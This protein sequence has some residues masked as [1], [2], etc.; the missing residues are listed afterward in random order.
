MP[1]SKDPQGGGT[2]AD[3]TRNESYCSYCYADGRFTFDGTIKEFQEFCRNAMKQS[4]M[5]GFA[6]WL[7]SRGMKR[8]PRWRNQQGV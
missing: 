7:F 1:M 5:S 6:A 4:G 2:N 8:L 3:G